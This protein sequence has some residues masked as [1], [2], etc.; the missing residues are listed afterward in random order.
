FLDDVPV[1]EV[2]QWESQFLQFVRSS[3]AEVLTQISDQ[4]ELN[5]EVTQLVE[6]ALNDFKAQYVS[7]S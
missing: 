3:K 1:N 5:D 4:G 6:N 7:S 2:S